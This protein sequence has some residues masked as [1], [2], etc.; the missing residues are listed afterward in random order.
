M[1]PM[2]EGVG[3]TKICKSLQNDLSLMTLDRARLTAKV[4]G[5]NEE[6]EHCH[7]NEAF[8]VFK[9]WFL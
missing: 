8:Q 5:L 6:I 1:S 4:V 9:E 2:D 7:E 3:E